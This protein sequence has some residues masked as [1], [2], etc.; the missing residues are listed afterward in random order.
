VSDIE[1]HRRICPKRKIQCDD[2]VEKVSVADMTA[3]VRE[4]HKES[5][6]EKFDVSQQ[7]A[8]RR[9][10]SNFSADRTAPKKNLRGALAMIGYTGKF[11]CGSHQETC[12]LQGC[13]D[14]TCGKSNGCNCRACMQ[15]DVQARSLPPGFLINRQGRACRVS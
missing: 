6:I 8:L 10:L 14:G 11:Y 7:K 9:K 13:C 2:C 4:H 5:L 1:E 15:L 3:H 12:S